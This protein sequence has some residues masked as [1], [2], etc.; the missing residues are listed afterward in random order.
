MGSIDN[1]IYINCEIQRVPNITQEFKFV[2][3][4]VNIDETRCAVVLGETH[5]NDLKENLSKKGIRDVSDEE[6]L[7]PIKRNKKQSWL[8]PFIPFR[9]I[10]QNNLVVY[11]VENASLVVLQLN[12]DAIKCLDNYQECKNKENKENG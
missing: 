3:N 7:I 6:F 10:K 9:Y 11:S 1:K 12:G 8:P 2:Y 5:D 4:E